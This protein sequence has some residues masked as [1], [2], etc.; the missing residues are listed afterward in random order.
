MDPSVFIVACEIFSYDMWDL[1]PWS[2]IEPGPP[3][4]GA[5]SLSHWTTREVL[6]S[7]VW[8]GFGSVTIK[9]MMAFD[10]AGHYDKPP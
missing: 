3:A 7:S 2:G 5:W 9:N 10:S 6:E 1:V 8:K 4:L